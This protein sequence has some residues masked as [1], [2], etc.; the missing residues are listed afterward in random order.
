M[1]LCH[2][3]S[4]DEIDRLLD[5]NVHEA[6]EQLKKEGKVRFLGFSTHTPKLIEVANAASTTGAST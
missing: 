5:P 3:H 6:Y 4:V 2:I 1:D